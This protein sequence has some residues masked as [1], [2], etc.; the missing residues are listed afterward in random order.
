SYRRLKVRRQ[1]SSPRT[2]PRKKKSL[3]MKKPSAGCTTT[4]RW[5]PT[6]SPKASGASTPT[7]ASSRTSSS[8]SAQRAPPPNSGT[9]PELLQRLFAQPLPSKQHEVKH[10][11][12]GDRQHEGTQRFLRLLGER[13]DGSDLQSGHDHPDD[14]EE[15]PGL[16]PE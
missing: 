10:G 3:S 12:D 5:R 15:P 16:L 4:T 11:R 8:R 7:R 1:E 2:C 6:S 13:E 14:R 9:E